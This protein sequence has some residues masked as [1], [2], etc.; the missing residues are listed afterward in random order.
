MRGK[1][2]EQKECEEKCAT[3]TKPLAPSNAA[4]DVEVLVAGVA[5]GAGR[6]E[7][8]HG[9]AG[10]RE[11]AAMA[12]IRM[13]NGDRCELDRERAL[14]GLPGSPSPVLYTG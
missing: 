13:P 11:S 4:L 12:A 14:D 6:S 5:G 2:N 1:K 3:H 7:G 9:R 8:A 10:A